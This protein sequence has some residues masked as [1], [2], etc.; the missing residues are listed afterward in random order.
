VA[1]NVYKL[2]DFLEPDKRQ[3][4][5]ATLTFTSEGKFEIKYDYAK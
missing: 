5:V 1:Q 2:N 4:K 3:W